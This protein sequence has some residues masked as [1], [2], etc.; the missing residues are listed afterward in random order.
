LLLHP[1]PFR[2][3]GGDVAKFFIFLSEEE[4]SIADWPYLLW[5]EQENWNEFG[6]DSAVQEESGTT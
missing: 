4:S 2:N 3:F 5:R 1:V 6:S